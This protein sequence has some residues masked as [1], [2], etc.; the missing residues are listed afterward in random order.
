MRYITLDTSRWHWV[1]IT[2]AVAGAISLISL[3]CV[4]AFG[5]LWYVV[6]AAVVAFMQVQYAFTGVCP[7]VWVLQLCGVKE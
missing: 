1:R 3:L 6:P 4:L 7:L 2:Y 5:S